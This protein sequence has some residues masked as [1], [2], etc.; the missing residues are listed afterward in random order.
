MRQPQGPLGRSLP[1]LETVHEDS[2]GDVL[3][4]ESTEDRDENEYDDPAEYIEAAVLRQHAH[5]TPDQCWR[6]KYTESLG[7][8]RAVLEQLKNELEQKAHPEEF[9]ENLAAN[10]Q[11]K[12]Q[13]IEEVSGPS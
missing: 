9:A 8:L 6:Q 5:C 3:Q 7:Q 12:V 4:E 13:L 11:S 10:R 1:E 2:P